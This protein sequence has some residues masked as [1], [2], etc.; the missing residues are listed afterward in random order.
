M[1]R[2]H[3]T[4]PRCWTISS[5]LLTWTAWLGC[6]V[7]FVPSASGQSDLEKNEFPWA[8]Y[9]TSRVEE[10]EAQ[11]EQDLSKITR[12]NWSDLQQ[13]W[14]AELQEMLGLKPWPEKTPLAAQ[15]TA[16][17]EGDGYRVENIHFQPSPKLFVGANL[18]LPTG[19]RPNAGWPVVLYVCGHARVDEFGRLAG[20][21][22]SYQHHGIWF[23]RHGMACLIVDTIQ[24]GEFQGE[25]HGT[26]KL[27]RW[28]WISKGYTPAGV[29]AWT[30]MRA[31][32]YLESRIE[33]DSERIGVTGRSGGGAYSWYAAALDPRIRAVVPVAG[34]TDLRNHVLDG[35]VEGHCDCMYMVNTFRWD[36]GKLAALIAP[37]PL[38]LTNTDSD[39]IFPLDGVIRIHRQLESLYR[40][41][42]KPQDYGLLIGPGP[43]KDSQELQVG[44]FKW[45]HLHLTGKEI[46]VDRAATK[47]LAPHQLV[48]FPQEL[49]L[50]EKVTGAA[51]WFASKDTSPRPENWESEGKAWIK[52]IETIE[53]FESR[54]GAFENAQMLQSGTG[55]KWKWT[56]YSTSQESGWP[57]EWLR[58]EPN[59]SVGEDTTSTEKNH[60]LH[61]GISAPRE[62][63]FDAAGSEWIRAILTS[64]TISQE[65]ESAPTATHWILLPRGSDLES[66]FP[67]VKTRTQFHRR[68]YLVGDSLEQL[69]FRDACGFWDWARPDVTREL[70][71]DTLA[72]WKII[73]HGRAGILATLLT[74]RAIWNEATN[75]TAPEVVVRNV[76]DDWRLQSVFPGF[77]AKWQYSQIV[78]WLG[79]RTTVTK[80]TGSEEEGPVELVDPSNEPQQSTGMKIVEVGSHRATVWSRSTRWPL[81]NLGD[82]PQV[83]FSQTTPSG[84]RQQGAILPAD[85]IAG[86]RFGVPGVPAEMRVRWKPL[87]RGTWLASPWQQADE[88]TDYSLLTS[89]SDLDANTLYEVR[90]EARVSAKGPVSVHSGQFKTLPL[91]DERAPLRLAVGTCQEFDDRDGPFGFEAYRTMRKRK[92]DCFFMA[93]DV[94]YYDKLARSVPLA[95]Y[96]WQRTYGL[97]SVVDFHRNIPA[98]FLKDDHDTYVDDSWPGKRAKWTDDFTFEDGQR[99]FRTQTGLPDTPYRTFRM[100]RDL[101]IWM[102][103]G[104]DFRTPN[105]AP[106][107][108][109]KSI[110][111][112]EQKRWLMETLAESH[113]KYRVVISPTPIV[114]PDRESKKDNHSNSVF[115]TEG[116]AIRAA[117][118]KIPGCLVICG[119]RHWQYHSIDPETGLQEFSVGPISNRHAGGWKK[120]DFRPDFHQFLRV[121]GGYLELELTYAADTPSLHI[122]HLDPFGATVHDVAR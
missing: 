41:V 66:R 7:L 69:Q 25:H 115:A 114:G 94:V 16:T 59:A 10:I 54:K 77:A 40:Q 34:I 90:T 22:T 84:Q 28:D 36:Y 3:D 81:P 101:Q 15:V 74:W 32:D 72:S 33:M 14:R 102:L 113:A 27:G 44:A 58:V 13:K 107:S 87:G 104:R 105:V 2:L 122:R 78:E 67:G 35:C 12:E 83:E 53:P 109:E 88:S 97:P 93:G 42:G 5:H 73:G 26:Y 89:L 98:Y 99:I 61:L 117:L 116:K 112:V 39:S 46:L 63:G 6:I 75:A 85:S 60:L 21:K 106:D 19:E 80:L 29:E 79:D 92:T 50:D 30:C 38:L 118:S 48:A 18:Y 100:G 111:G 8:P 49:P 43:H 23:A 24:L 37:R 52:R 4:C 20:N 9:L 110:L 51:Q 119:D 91:P 70:N 47:E 95:F 86:L 56:R 120:E 96:H 103:E 17:L 68:L 55:D 71:R 64:G 82:L 57:A 108:D 31:I 121:A 11:T 65:L 1:V 62:N 45:L 76:N